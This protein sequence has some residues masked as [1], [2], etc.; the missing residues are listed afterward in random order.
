MRYVAASASLTAP[1]VV[2][3]ERVG[4]CGDMPGELSAQPASLLS[5]LLWLGLSKAGR[6]RP[7]LVEV[8]EE[9]VTPTEKERL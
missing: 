7:V 5:M 8:S 6:P 1:E 2:I 3:A 9:E 4:G